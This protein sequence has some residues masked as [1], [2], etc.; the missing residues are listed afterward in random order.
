V[1]WLEGHPGRPE[2]Y[3]ITHNRVAHKSR[4]SRVDA[5]WPQR[6]TKEHKEQNS[7]KGNAESRIQIQLE[8]DGGGSTEQDLKMEKTG[9]WPVFHQEQ[10]SLTKSTK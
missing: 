4:N 10:Q 3:S 7:Q 5:K 9:L 8:E 6:T 1:E 2:M